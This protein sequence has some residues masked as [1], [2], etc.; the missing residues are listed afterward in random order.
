MIIA[1]TTGQFDLLD[2]HTLREVSYDR[3]YC[4]K[5]TVFIDQRAAR[6]D[7][8]I[9]ATDLPDEASDELWASYLAE[10]QGDLDLA[11]AS[12]KSAF[13]PKDAGEGEKAPE[14]KAPRAKK[15]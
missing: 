6:G 8:K 13:E 5:P 2:P 10:S 7:V 3:P 1:Q 4:I 15:A 11:V 9:I 12:F 14:P